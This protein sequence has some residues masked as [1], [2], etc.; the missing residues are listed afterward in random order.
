MRGKNRIIINFV[1]CLFCST[2]GLGQRHPLSGR[3]GSVVISHVNVISM[4][5]DQVL[6][7]QTVVVWHGKVIKI[8]RSE[9]NH[10]EKLALQIDGSGKYL[11][12]GLADLHVHLFSSDDLLSYV[13]N[14]VTTVMNMHGEPPDLRWREQ[15][16]KGRLLG[17]TIY[18][19][20]PAVDGLPP[21]KRNVCHGG[22][23]QGCRSLCTR[24]QASW[25]RFH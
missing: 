2:L 23:A 9:N 18:T 16:L 1:L 22:E 4:K 5:D 19:A 15:V 14:G 7:D 25:I 12:P 6:A 3:D 17:P 21:L 8:D 10:H 24:Q 20:S 11:M 13:A